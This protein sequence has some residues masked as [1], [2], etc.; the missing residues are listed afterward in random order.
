MRVSVETLLAEVETVGVLALVV[1]QTVDVF[2]P[3][4]V[5]FTIFPTRRRLILVGASDLDILNR[6]ASL[7]HPKTFDF[8]VR[9]FA[10]PLDQCL[11]TA[12]VH[13]F[14]QHNPSS[15]E[16]LVGHWVWSLAGK[17]A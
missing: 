5:L 12:S 4:I 16:Y 10:S 17:S 7:S 6:Y 2:D 8:E 15:L 11:E 3:G 1:R 13:G 14:S 9:V